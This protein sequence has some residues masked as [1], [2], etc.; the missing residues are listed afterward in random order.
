MHVNPITHDGL[1]TIGYDADGVPGRWPGVMLE[2]C[3]TRDW[4]EYVPGNEFL[5]MD[6]AP[7]TLVA[8]GGDGVLCW[9]GPDGR[10]YDPEVVLEQYGDK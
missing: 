6:W 10:V 5:D 2:S 3:E 1:D 9:Q 8:R 7:W 4:V